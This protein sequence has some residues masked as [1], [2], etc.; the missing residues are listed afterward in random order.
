MSIQHMSEMP[1][2]KASQN[3]VDLLFIIVSRLAGK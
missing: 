2:S 3:S 1:G